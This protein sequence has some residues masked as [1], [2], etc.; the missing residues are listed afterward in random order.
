MIQGFEEHTSNIKPE[1]IEISQ[2]IVSIIKQCKSK[3]RGITNKKLRSVLFD[4]GYDV[5]DARIR[6]FIQFIR[7]NN[8]LPRM[9]GSKKGYYIAENEEEWVKYKIAF[10]TRITSMQYTLECMNREN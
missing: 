10:R 4:M 5:N 9:C 3:D 7:A 2:V 1:E 8:M 6:R